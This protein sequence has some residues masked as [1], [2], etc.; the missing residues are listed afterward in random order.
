MAQN[1]VLTEAATRATSTDI[2]VAAGSSVTVGLFATAGVPKNAKAVLRV[3]SPGADNIV[4]VL[5]TSNQQKVIAGPG[6]F[7]VERLEGTFGVFT[8]T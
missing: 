7:R 2:V 8:E 4:E 3:D 5:D 6:T 1:T